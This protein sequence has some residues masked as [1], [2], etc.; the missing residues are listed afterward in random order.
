MQKQ[1][2]VNPPSTDP[3]KQCGNL[4]SQIAQRII[5]DYSD[6]LNLK[7]ESSAVP[8]RGQLLGAELGAPELNNDFGESVASQGKPLDCALLEK[9][10][11]INSSA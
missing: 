2:S 4:S 1:R 10:E 7:K 9:Q 6:V 11:Q 3:N 5:L 8:Q